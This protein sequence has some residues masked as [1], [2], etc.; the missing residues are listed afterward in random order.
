[1]F[2]WPFFS[3][4]VSFGL[5]NKMMVTF[6][7]DN[8]MSFRHLFLKGYKDHRQGSYA[9]YT[10]S[11]VY[12]HIYFIIH[13]VL[14]CWRAANQSR[15][16]SDVNVNKSCLFTF[17]TS[18]SKTWLWVTWHMSWWTGNTPLCPCVRNFTGKA[19]SFLR[20]RPLILIQALIKVREQKG[21]WRS[22]PYI[23]N[24]SFRR[25]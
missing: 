11:A 24:C 23:S 15:T 1:M 5:S 3:Q 12:D 21:P 2:V 8:L 17:S 19:T 14:T 13:K 7:D 4:L 20:T 22:E 25:L 18:I 10:K 6:K 16:T 9:L